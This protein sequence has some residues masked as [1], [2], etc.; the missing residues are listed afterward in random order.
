MPWSDWPNQYLPIPD[1][2]HTPDPRPGWRRPDTLAAGKA[3][4]LKLLADPTDFGARYFSTV[5]T[6]YGDLKDH[7][8]DYRALVSEAYP[9]GYAAAFNANDFANVHHCAWLQ[10]GYALTTLMNQNPHGDWGDPPAN[11]SSHPKPGDEIEVANAL[12]E[13]LVLTIPLDLEILFYHY[14]P[15]STGYYAINSTDITP[16]NSGT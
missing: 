1:P 10:I 5:R 15:N 2:T 4:A 3:L 11:G 8:G 7:T 14:V 6:A 13:P 16:P 12:G 9:D